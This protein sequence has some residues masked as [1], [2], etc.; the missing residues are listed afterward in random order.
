M[1]RYHIYQLANSRQGEV[2]FETCLIDV[3]EVDAD[4][5]FAA[6]RLSQDRV[7]ESLRVVCHS[8][9]IGLQQSV[10]LFAESLAS[11]CVHLSRLLLDWLDIWVNG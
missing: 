8:D 4:F 10:N 1:T 5:P 7:D 2:F 6:F 11:L 9:E 3:G